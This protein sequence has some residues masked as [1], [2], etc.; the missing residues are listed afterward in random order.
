M[1]LVKQLSQYQP[2]SYI[3]YKIVL[4]CTS[5]SLPAG[6]VADFRQV[7]DH[8]NEGEVDIAFTCQDTIQVPATTSSSTGRLR[9]NC[10]VA[11]ATSP[12]VYTFPSIYSG[13]PGGDSPVLDGSKNEPPCPHC[14]FG[15][16]I[17]WGPPV[18]LTG[19]AAPSLAN[20]RNR[21]RLYTSNSG[22]YW[23]TWGC[24]ITQHTWEGRDWWHT[25]LIEGR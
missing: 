10:L 22:S 15:P 23:K 11:I 5:G 14:L 25:H 1:Q 6:F 8:H 16:C 18:F 4:Q 3:L 19:R 20:D 24:G 2:H 21:L 7:I 17:I 9:G 13:Y 12:H